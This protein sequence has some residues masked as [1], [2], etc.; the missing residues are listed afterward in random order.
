MEGRREPEAD[1]GKAGGLPPSEPPH[2]QGQ[3]PQEYGYGT[4]QGPRHPPVGFPQP[5]PPPGLG[6][7]GGGGGYHNQKQPYAPAETYYA[8]GYQAVPGMLR[9]SRSLRLFA[10][11]LL[12]SLAVQ[13][14]KAAAGGAAA[15][16][17]SYE[18]VIVESSERFMI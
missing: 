11:A 15:I 16:S 6:G 4:F 1:G 14:G 13:W 7:G 2:L 17:S 12:L 10:P 3:P 8:Q 5:A 18:A 9:S